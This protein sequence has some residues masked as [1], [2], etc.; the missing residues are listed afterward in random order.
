VKV[1]VNGKQAR[2]EAIALDGHMI[3]TV[4]LGASK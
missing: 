4:D 1:S 3:D 2:V